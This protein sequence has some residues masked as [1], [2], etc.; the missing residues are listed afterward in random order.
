MDAEK[1]MIPCG[2][3]LCSIT[4]PERGEK[5]FCCDKHRVAEYNLEHPRVDIKS[6]A[7]IQA[8]LAESV[9]ENVTPVSIVPTVQ[10][11]RTFHFS[12]IDRENER[13]EILRKTLGFLTYCEPSTREINEY[14]GSTRASSDISELRE[15]GF[16]IECFKAK[17]ESGKDINRFRLLPGGK[18][19]AGKFFMERRIQREAKRD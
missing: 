7:K 2:Y 18:E 12:R 5:K 17:S 14:S 1:K 6:Q 4:F 10:K 15:Q 3:R 13:G 11:K 8:V 19:K 16:P 9:S